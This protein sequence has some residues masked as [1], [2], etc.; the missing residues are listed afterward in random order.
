M[1][2]VC[3][4]IRMPKTRKNGDHQLLARALSDGDCR[5]LG[6]MRPRPGGSLL[7]PC[8]PAAPS[9]GTHPRDTRIYVHTKH[10][11]SFAHNG[12]DRG[13]PAVLQGYGSAVGHR[14]GGRCSRYEGKNADTREKSGGI[15]LN[16]KSQL[17]KVMFWMIPF[18]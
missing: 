10:A 17:R 6:G 7:S 8:G 11:R 9:P 18:I 2:C 15:M 16:G 14:T 5:S 3:T 12:P 13:R 1:R 4:P